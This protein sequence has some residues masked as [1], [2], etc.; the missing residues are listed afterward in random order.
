MLD[1]AEKTVESHRGN[2]LRKLGMRDRVDSCATRSAAGC[3]GVGRALRRR[4]PAAVCGLRLPSSL[5]VASRDGG[6]RAGRGAAADPTPPRA[7]GAAS[8]APCAPR[9]A[10]RLPAERRGRQ[11]GVDADFRGRTVV[12]TFM[13]TTCED[14]CPAKA[15]RSAARSTTSA[16]RAR[17]RRQRRPRND[18]RA[19]APRF[20]LEQR[21]RAACASCSARARAAPVW[22]G[23]GMRRRRALEHSAYVVLLDRG[24]ASS[25]SAS[26]RAADPRGLAS[27]VRA[28]SP[29]RLQAG[30]AAAGWPRGIPARRARP[31]APW[32]SAVPAV[33][34]GPSRSASRSSASPDDCPRPRFHHSATEISSTGSRYS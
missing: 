32:S 28:C 30:V 13:Y 7:R 14:T 27:D 34:P 24:A 12:M 21:L 5:S 25:A 20:L 33:P 29:S 10:A 19:R 26:R 1:L 6:R 9:P 4:D 3:R 16:R 23:F 18:T 8:T 15:Q 11:A 2:I 31:P 17:D 22:R